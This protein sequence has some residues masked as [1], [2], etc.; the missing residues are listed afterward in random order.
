L[1]NKKKISLTLLIGFI[2]AFAVSLSLQFQVKAVSLSQASACKFAAT[3][4]TAA[5]LNMVRESLEDTESRRTG[6]NTESFHVRESALTIA[7]QESF[8]HYFYA[9]NSPLDRR[10]LYLDFHKLLI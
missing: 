1:R 3:H 7:E 4:S 2:L 10:K 5:V 6:F 8:A 9:Q